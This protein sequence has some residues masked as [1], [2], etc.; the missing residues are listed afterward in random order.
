MNVVVKSTKRII[1]N[2]VICIF[3]SIALIV[4]LNHYGLKAIDGI[5]A[6]TSGESIY[7]KAQQEASRQLT[8]YVFTANPEYYANFLTQLQVPINDSLARISLDSNLHHSISKKHLLLGKNIPEDLDNIIWVYRNFKS[9]SQ[10]KKAI[11]IWKDADQLIISLEN[12]GKAIDKQIKQKTIFNPAEKE[13]LARGIDKTC[14]LLTQK[15]NEFDET[16]TENSRLVNKAVLTINTLMAFII[17]ICIVGISVKYI[18]KISV[19]QKDTLAQNKALLK[20]NEEM[21]LFTHSVSHDLRSPITSLKG[22]IALAELEEE[23]KQRNEY[24]SLMKR[25][26]SRQ[27]DF[28]LK[29]IQFSKNKRT[30]LHIHEIHLPSFFEHLVQDLEHSSDIEIDIKLDVENTVI[31]IDAFRL[32]IICKNLISNAIKYADP[33]KAAP[34]IKISAKTQ[35]GLLNLVFE[36]NGIGIDLEHQQ[37]IFNMFYV[38][39]HQNKGS[40]IGLYLVKEMINKLGGEIKVSSSNGN[41]SSFTI[42]IPTLA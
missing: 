19:L 30:D 34:F 38:T 26:L 28:I 3:I 11:S 36:D 41:G 25:I 12:Q 33:K 29:I 7:M 32:D 27:D 40:G 35:K 18:H 39:T 21:D 22:I 24:F 10:F 14:K 6:F 37:K 16:L 5:R 20:T 31:C 17:F 1:Y 42:T 4:G 15:G 2:Y 9:L 8:N 23:E 13:Q